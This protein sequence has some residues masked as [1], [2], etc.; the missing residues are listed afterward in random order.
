[1]MHI[2]HFI[3]AASAGFLCGALLC[4]CGTKAIIQRANAPSFEGEI[5]KSD[6]EYL[7][8]ELDYSATPMTIP[9][10]EVRD[11]DHPGNVAAIIGGILSA[12]GVLN[13]IAGVEQCDKSAAFCS[14]VFLPA[15][16]GL[17]TMIYGIAVWHRSV[18]AAEGK[19]NNSGASLSL[20]PLASFQKSKEFGGASISLS[21]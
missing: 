5:V 17:P 9:R 11:I 6:S 15:S 10:T 21:Y 7:Y 20:S 19:S 2:R 1:M 8:V 4:G 16:I 18:S 14:G 13:I 12:Y 3:Q